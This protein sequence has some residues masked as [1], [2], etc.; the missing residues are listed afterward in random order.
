LGLRQLLD[1]L[2]LLRLLSWRPRLLRR[3]CHRLL[4]LQMLLRGQ[5]SL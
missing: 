5:R 4:L 2:L 1:L 3:C